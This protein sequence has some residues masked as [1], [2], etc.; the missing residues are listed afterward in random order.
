MGW[1][2]KENKMWGVNLQGKMWGAKSKF[3][4]FLPTSTIP[5]SSSGSACSS[6]L[7]CSLAMRLTSLVFYKIKLTE[8]SEIL[9]SDHASDVNYMLYKI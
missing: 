5:L 9:H 8:N 6:F 2:L 1:N 7:V 4:Y 3:S